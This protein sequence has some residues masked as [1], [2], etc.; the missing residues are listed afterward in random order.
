[1]RGADREN[2]DAVSREL[3]RIGRGRLDALTL[4]ELW[5]VVREMP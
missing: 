5:S 3:G 2:I 1:L 4:E